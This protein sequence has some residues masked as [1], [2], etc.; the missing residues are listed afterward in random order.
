MENIHNGYGTTISKSVTEMARYGVL[1]SKCNQMCYYASLC[2]EG[3]DE[4]MPMITDLTERMRQVAEN[5]NCSKKQ[6]ANT[7]DHEKREF[8]VRDPMWTKTKGNNEKG[9]SSKPTP[10]RCSKCRYILKFIDNFHLT[11]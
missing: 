6:K 4:L 2:T 7:I 3:Y 11:K 5:T 9:G 8:D 10:R 1:S